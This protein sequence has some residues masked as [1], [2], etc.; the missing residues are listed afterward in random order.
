MN[1][2]LINVNVNE[3]FSAEQS[4]GINGHF[5]CI[6]GTEMTSALTIKTSLHGR[7]DALLARHGPLWSALTPLSRSASFTG[8][9][10]DFLTSREHLFHK[11]P[12]LIWSN[13]ATLTSSPIVLIR[14]TG[15]HVLWKFN[16]WCINLPSQTTK[17]F[18][19]FLFVQHNVNSYI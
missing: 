15:N 1:R 14:L 19:M 7:N 16:K 4:A 9:T 5:T 2:R 8:Q 13:V 3:Y 11:Q 18:L 10:V 6:R 12:S 17:L